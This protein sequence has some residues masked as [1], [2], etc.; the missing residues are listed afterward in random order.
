MGLFKHG[1]FSRPGSHYK[2]PKR[3]GY[4]EISRE[5]E[6][7]YLKRW[8]L[9]RCKRFS[10]RIHHFTGPDPD[11]VPHDHPWDFWSIPFRGWYYESTKDGLRRVRWLSHHK[12]EDYHKV[13]VLCRPKGVWTLFITGAERREWGF[14]T[15]AGWVPYA[16][17][18]GL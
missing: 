10:I 1:G 11:D 3:W 2:K 13:L 4:I 7:P 15:P 12:A 8:Y 9:W 14:V 16:D 6:E 5:G 18:L 17:Y